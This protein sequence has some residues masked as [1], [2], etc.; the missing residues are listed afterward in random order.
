MIK[1]AKQTTLDVIKKKLSLLN[2]LEYNIK[3]GKIE[4]NIGL[5]LFFLK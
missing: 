2:E 4:Q 5:E 1:N 3:I